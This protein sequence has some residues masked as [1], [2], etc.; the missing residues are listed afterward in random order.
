MAAMETLSDAITRLTD[1]GY[2]EA[3]HSDGGQLVCGRCDTRFEPSDVTVD[4][5]VRFEG[6]SDPG[7]Q[8][9]LYALVAGCNH[10]G[11]YSLAYGPAATKDDIKVLLELPDHTP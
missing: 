5:I 6:A 1:A 10:R 2:E 11:F 8:A 4:E 7:D 3:F 9:I